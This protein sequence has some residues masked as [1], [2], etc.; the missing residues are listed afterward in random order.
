MSE[1]YQNAS[2]RFLRRT[3]IENLVNERLAKRGGPIGRLFTAL[4]IGKRQ[5]GQHSI[6]RIMK[7]M[8]YWWLM[9]YQT[10]G[11][12]RV[13]FSR[14]VGLQNAPLNYSGLFVWFV[15]TNM[16]FSRFRFTRSREVMN[17][18]QQDQPEFWYSRYGMMFPPSFLHSRLS[19]HYIEINH[20]FFIEQMKKY[21][22]IR[23]EMIDEREACTPEE[24]LT[25]YATNPNYVYEPLGADD[26]KL[27]RVKD[28]GLM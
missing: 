8:N 2:L 20:I 21:I 18:N 25:R 3:G 28:L 9:I 19:A 6:G 10:L 7:L 24:R 15:A 17:F 26:D 4:S 11:Q 22:G 12:Q 16:I 5:F 27:R 13:V 1:R 14:F 23:K